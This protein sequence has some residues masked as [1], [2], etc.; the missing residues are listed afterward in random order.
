MFL[1]GHVLLSYFECLMVVNPNAWLQE[2]YGLDTVVLPVFGY[3]D[4]LITQKNN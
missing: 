1:Q 2:Y 3:T 4:S